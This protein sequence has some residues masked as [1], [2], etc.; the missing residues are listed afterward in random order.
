MALGLQ[1]HKAQTMCAA[2]PSSINSLGAF[3][4]LPQGSTPIDIARVAASRSPAIFA[5]TGVTW[6]CPAAGTSSDTCRRTTRRCRRSSPRRTSLHS[7]GSPVEPTTRR[8]SPGTARTGAGSRAR[9][10]GRSRARHTSV[11]GSAACARPRRGC[12]APPSAASPRWRRRA[13]RSHC[14]HCVRTRHS[15][16]TAPDEGQ[17]CV[18][19]GLASGC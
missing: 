14:R 7:Q 16:R 19:V 11:G 12:P 5:L 9:G 17:S 15:R 18:G 10:K 4:V 8:A 2:A 1:M 6:G 13:L 3:R